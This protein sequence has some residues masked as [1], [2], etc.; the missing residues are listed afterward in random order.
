MGMYVYF[1]R[2]YRFHRS[3]ECISVL[4]NKSV[5]FKRNLIIYSI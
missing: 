3:V 4:L 5:E 1:S 2:K